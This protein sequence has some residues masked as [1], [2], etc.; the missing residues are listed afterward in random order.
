MH[1]QLMGKHQAAAG[2]LQGCT[3]TGFLSFLRLTLGVANAGLAWVLQQPDDQKACAPGM[4][5]HLHEYVLSIPVRLAIACRP[6][7]S[8]VKTFCSTNTLALYTKH[9]AHR[10]WPVMSP[11]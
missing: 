11:V 1:V 4:T 9:Q 5:Q 2:T 10:F 8:Y 3:I 7:I 6:T